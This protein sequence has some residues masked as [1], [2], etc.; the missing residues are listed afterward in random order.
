MGMM[1]D[2]G[3]KQALD[4][5]TAKIV[6]DGDLLIL[7]KSNTSESLSRVIGDIT[8]S[9]FAGYSA[10]T[11]TGYGAA[12]VASHVASSAATPHTYTITSGTENVYGYAR[13]NSARTKL[14]WYAR[15]PA[16]PIGMDAALINQLAVTHTVTSNDETV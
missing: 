15:D 14:Y 2:E 5:R 16:A 12:T 7:V 13:V 9:T 1:S 4:A 8:E 11:L 10:Y 3:I 6:A